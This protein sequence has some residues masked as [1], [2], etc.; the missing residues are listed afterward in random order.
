MRVQDTRGS[1]SEFRDLLFHV[2]FPIQAFYSFAPLAQ[3]AAG[4]VTTILPGSDTAHA[5]SDGPRIEI[6]GLV[7]GRALDV[8]ALLSGGIRAVD[9]SARPHPRVYPQGVG[10]GLNEPHQNL[11]VP[12]WR[13]QLL[14]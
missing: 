8:R 10:G 4:G 12:R 6:V 7:Q 14:G 5:E 11:C 9:S 1:V 13:L 2:H 3:S